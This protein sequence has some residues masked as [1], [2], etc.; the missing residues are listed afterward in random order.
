MSTMKNLPGPEDITRV[1]LANG[2][3]VLARPNFQSPS[4]VI[5]GYLAAGSLFDPKN[6]GGLSDF[7]SGALMHGNAVQ[8]FQE[9]YDLLEGVGASCGFSGGTHTT[10]FGG[11]SLVEDLDIMLGVIRN[12]LLEPTFPIEHF[13][14]RRTQI[15]THLSIRAQD[16]AEMASQCFDEILYADHPYGLPED[17]TVESVQAIQ[18]Q[19]LQ[20]FHRQHYGPKGCIISIVGGVDP[21]AA[22]E[23]VQAYLGDWTNPLQKPQ[24]ELPPIQELKETIRKKVTLPAKSQS[25]LLIGVIGP[26]RAAPEYLTAT[27]G[28]NI[29]GQFGMYGRIGH[30]VREKSGLAYYAYSHVSGGIGPGIWCAGAGVDPANV[31]Q[32]IDL[33]LAEFRKFTQELVTP[34]ELEDTKAN[35]IGRLP[36][37]FESNSGVAGSLI[38]L[39]RYQ[40]GLDYFQRYQNMIQE[41]TAENILA[42][43]QKYLDLERI[44]V[45]VAGS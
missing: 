35:F 3:V 26:N 30:S 38:H 43:A 16:T 36:L 18:R 12:S 5:N 25:D 2:I 42:A 33:I 24:P 6:L 21:L 14:R 29:L 39:E 44:A 28:N 8:S 23:K 17:G 9:I 37:G 11:R 4:V 41:T 1:E 32:A 27:V 22:V 45:V 13:E 10:S 34:E 20:E 19:D 31:D 15:L 7:T 40:L